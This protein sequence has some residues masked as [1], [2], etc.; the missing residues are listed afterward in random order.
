MTDKWDN[1]MIRACK[2][3]NGT[4]DIEML[5]YIF[6]KRCGLSD[7]FPKIE[8]LHEI[9]GR[10]W[11]IIEKFELATL[12]EVVQLFNM[13]D[14]Y[15]EDESKFESLYP[16]I[17]QK[18]AFVLGRAISIIARTRTDRFPEDF[19]W[20]LRWRHNCDVK[21]SPYTEDTSGL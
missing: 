20:G 12:T 1:Y 5:D 2:F 3:C 4:E 18:T 13:P 16:R 8:L 10:L 7:D 15:Y 17:D 9:A 14:W 11:T 21:K 19:Y 6:R